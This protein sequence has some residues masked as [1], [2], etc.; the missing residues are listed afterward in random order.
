MIISVKVFWS[1]KW[2]AVFQNVFRNVIFGRLLEMAGKKDETGSSPGSKQHEASAQKVHAYSA[3][4]KR[5]FYLVSSLASSLVFCVSGIFHEIIHYATLRGL[6]EWRD[7]QNQGQYESWYPYFSSY[8]YVNSPH[9]Y[10]HLWETFAFFLVHGLLS[11]L[12]T[13]VQKL[14]PALRHGTGSW[15]ADAACNILVLYL[16]LPLYFQGNL[17]SDFWAKMSFI[18]RSE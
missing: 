10:P 17:M 4:E 9:A 16:T 18:E 14:I 8:T 12:Q 5:Y 2:N 7:C 11:L 6:T 13:S 15:I 1:E 3:A